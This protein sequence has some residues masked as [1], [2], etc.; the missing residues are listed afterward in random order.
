MIKTG[1]KTDTFIPYIPILLPP[2]MISVAITSKKTVPELPLLT[3]TIAKHVSS[4]HKLSVTLEDGH[5]EN[6]NINVAPIC[7]KLVPLF[8]DIRHI[9]CPGISISRDVL[10]KLGALR[11]LRV[12][13]CSIRCDEDSSPS[14]LPFNKALYPS[15]KGLWIRT[16]S[17]PTFIIDLLKTCK[18]R[19][20][21]F[22]Y[23]CQLATHPPSSILR[24]LMTAL[25]T[26]KNL[27]VLCLEDAQDFASTNPQ[28]CLLTDAIIRPLY[29]CRSL[30]TLIL[31]C[32]PSALDDTA[33]THMASAWPG[34][35]IL[36]LGTTQGCSADFTQVTW[37]ALTH[38][39]SRCPGLT[40]ID[41]DLKFCADMMDAAL[42]KP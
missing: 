16:K 35:K 20:L 3:E 5:E 42:R 4:L 6:A 29:Q 13:S 19:D 24:A 37:N 17:V 33:I 11:E 15:L 27:S 14:H 39:V 23:F 8:E 28:E 12:L 22:V 34:L 26:L 21:E 1:Q 41:L 2:K 32:C 9:A 25:G 7:I 36:G 31:P 18:L 38:L 30:E 40:S 10:V